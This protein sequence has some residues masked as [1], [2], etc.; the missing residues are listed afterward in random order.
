MRRVGFVIYPGKL[1]DAD[2][3][4]IGTIGHIFPQDIRD[5]MAAVQRVRGEMQIDSAHAVSYA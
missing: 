3:F 4:R 5:L 1:S 2:C